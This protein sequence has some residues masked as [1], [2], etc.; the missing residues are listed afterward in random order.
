[1]LEF[2]QAIFSFPDAVFVAV[3]IVV[4]ILIWRFR[5]LD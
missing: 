4:A 1:M 2:L 3:M 5:K